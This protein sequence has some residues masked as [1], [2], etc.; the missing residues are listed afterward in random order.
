MYKVRNASSQSTFSE[1]F[2]PLI[3]DN[4]L[5]AQVV[6]PDCIKKYFR[7]E[8]YKTEDLLVIVFPTYASLKARIK[9]NLNKLNVKSWDRLVRGKYANKGIYEDHPG[10][11]SAM[12][13]HIILAGTA[14]ASGQGATSIELYAACQILASNIRKYCAGSDIVV[15]EFEIEDITDLVEA[16]GRVSPIINLTGGVHYYNK[17]RGCIII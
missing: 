11:L 8:F 12:S 6:W 5:D 15:R 7:D 14:D 17:K 16:S 9:E 4:L 2:I 13:Q 1:I 10:H 3:Y